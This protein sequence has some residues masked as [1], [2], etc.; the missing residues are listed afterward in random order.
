M[1]NGKHAREQRKGPFH[2]SSHNSCRALNISSHM[3]NAVN[4][5]TKNHKDEIQNKRVGDSECEDLIPSE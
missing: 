2:I 4:R 5:E 1:M 3:Y